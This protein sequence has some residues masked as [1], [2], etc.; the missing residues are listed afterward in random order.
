MTSRILRIVGLV[1]LAAVG[2][3]SVAAVALL[4]DR[5]AI[6]IARAPSSGARGPDPLALLAEDLRE[7]RE[8]FRAFAEGTA[9]R[10]D[11]LGALLEREC[12]AERDALRE[13]IAAL[14]VAVATPPL[15]GSPRESHAVSPETRPS[16]PASRRF[17]SFRLPSGGFDFDRPSRFL[18]V[19]SLSRVGFDA[20]STLHDFSGATTGVR[21]EF[22]SRL[23]HPS[24][25]AHGEIVVDAAALQT[26]LDARDEEM[27][28]LLDVG[29]HPTLRFEWTAFDTDA[30]DAAARTV[31]GTAKGRLSIRGIAREIALPVRISVDESRRIAVEGEAEIRLTDFGIP[32]PSKLGMIAMQDRVKIWVA[33]R[34][35]C[36]GPAGET[37]A[38]GSGG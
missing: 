31:R 1:T 9:E 27:R 26:G 38:K 29:A 20:K 23:S 22:S 13:E 8:E 2:A 4:R 30:V 14:R 25:V 11:A 37:A 17:L 16:A 10:L 33:L 21:G 36:A 15:E 18:V 34:A 19:E 6:T 24:E 3:A 35:R 5:V 12:A 28:A 7:S 32:V